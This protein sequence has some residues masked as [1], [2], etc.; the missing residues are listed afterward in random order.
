MSF[1]LDKTLKIIPNE[2]NFYILF[3]PEFALPS[4]KK[5]IS[6]KFKDSIKMLEEIHENYLEL[7]TKL[8][9]VQAVSKN[10]SIIIEDSK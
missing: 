10:L 1:S 3:Y 2:E 4:L 6:T 8:K 7:S 5:E 9:K